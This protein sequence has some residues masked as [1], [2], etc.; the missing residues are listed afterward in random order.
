MSHDYSIR[1]DEA[2]FIESYNRVAAE[3]HTRMVDKGFWGQTVQRNSAE[4]LMLMV[5]ELAEACEG[6]RH[7]DPPSDKIPEFTSSEE[8]LA[9][10][11][12]RIMDFGAG[13]GLRV[14]EALVRKMQY[15]QT[16]PAKHGKEF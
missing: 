15:N 16:R 1:N 9:D 4:A 14:A 11:I 8:E 12:I 6:F 3:I 10:T 5:T 7:G 13:T 2:E